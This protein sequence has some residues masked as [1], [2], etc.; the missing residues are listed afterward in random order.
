MKLDPMLINFTKE[1]NQ[2]R[3]YRVMSLLMDQPYPDIPTINHPVYVTPEENRT[4]NALTSSTIENIDNMILDSIQ[5][6]DPHLQSSWLERLH[7]HVIN[8]KKSVHIDFLLEVLASQ[9]TQRDAVTE[10]DIDDIIQ[11]M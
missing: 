4:K 10:I 9:E 5:I 2:K 6:M 8:Q 1:A 7:R 3:S 11:D